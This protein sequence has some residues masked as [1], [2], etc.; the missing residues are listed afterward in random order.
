LILVND[1]DEINVDELLKDKFTKL[2]I[3]SVSINNNISNLVE[4]K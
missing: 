4:I 3:A 1:I 2:F